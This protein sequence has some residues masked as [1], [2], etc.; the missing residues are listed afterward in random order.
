MP[1]VPRITWFQL[2][3]QTQGHLGYIGYIAK[4]CVMGF[5]TTSFF[6]SLF[7]DG[8]PTVA[9]PADQDPFPDCSPDDNRYADWVRRQ[10]VSGRWGWESP[11]LPEW[12]RWWARFTFDEL[13]EVPE[14]FRFGEVRKTACENAP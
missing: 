3:G 10:D 2:R 1:Y 6:E 13:P 8:L 12:R 7:G 9:G 14:G 4:V 5:D 11:G